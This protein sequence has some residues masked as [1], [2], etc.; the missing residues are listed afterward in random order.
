MRC[1]GTVPCHPDLPDVLEHIA[2]DSKPIERAKRV[3]LVK[4]QYIDKL[5]K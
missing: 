5:K 3:K 2:Y 4:K 1:Q